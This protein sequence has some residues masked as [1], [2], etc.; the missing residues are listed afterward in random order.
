MA[1][2]LVVTG[3][4]CASSQPYQDA[5]PLDARDVAIDR[6]RP[7]TMSADVTDVS[8]T[9]DA[10]PFDTAPDANAADV[11][12]SDASSRCAALAESYAL[13]VRE[14][15]SCMASLECTAL[16][17]ETLC[18]NCQVY[19][20]PASATYSSLARLSAEWASEGCPAEIACP[21]KVCDP[22]SSAQCSSTGRCVT[23]RRPSSK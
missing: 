16:V 22:P 3:M 13:A 12:G 5:G 15:Q 7:D 8:L 20:N 6:S 14:A 4:A 21:T 19:V 10:H 18:C 23:L 1:L 11:S 2:A 17:C 9:V